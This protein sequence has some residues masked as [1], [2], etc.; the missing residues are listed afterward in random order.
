M[1]DERM[2]SH[3]RRGKGGVGGGMNDS[4][5]KDDGKF[6]PDTEIVG[7][8]GVGQRKSGKDR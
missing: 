5:K 3:G 2:L 8:V 1:N 4:D 7:G 6:E